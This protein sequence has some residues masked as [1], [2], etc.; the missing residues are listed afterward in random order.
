MSSEREPT[1]ILRVIARL[2]MGGPAL[3]VAYLTA[4]LRERGYDTT[5]VA[6]TLARG[7]DSMAF[8][9]EGLHVDVVSIPEL[10]REISPVRDLAATLRLAALIRRERPQILHTHTAKAGTVGRVA[11]L[12][13]GR[14][15]PPIVVHTFH[16][17]V[18]Y[19]YF[20][21]LRSRFFRWLERWLA[22]HTTVLVAVSP[23]VRDDLVALGVAPPEK[24]VVVR[25][26]IELGERVGAGTNGRA[27]TRRYL[28]I[29][30]DRFAVGWVGRMTAVK[31]TDDVLDGF[32]RL[33]ER[34]VGATLCLVGDGP[35]RPAL[36]R[37]AHE[38]GIMRQTLFLGYQED[39]GPLYAA[40]DALVLP[41]GNEGTPVSVIEA[42]AAGT[43]VVATRVGGVP[44]VVRDGEDG[45]LVEPGASDELAQRLAQ[46]AGDPDL[47]QRFGASGRA[48]VLPRY[49]VDR[50]VD[51]VD[52]L[53]RALLSE[54]A[55]EKR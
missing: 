54:A 44:D 46:L 32:K 28:G 49:A 5:L 29:P 40:F 43:P 12:L 24:F 6:G 20:G 14:A 17:H 41:S 37:R 9:A 45:F 15:R 34:G 16:G 50:L 1:K 31:R 33:L 48:R 26:G 51:D 23:Q 21:P 39:V 19:G 55:G 2:N 42:L 7:E 36:E 27:E 30:P 4:G 25:L 8:V 11:A 47:R 52:R 18:L 10:G 38:L 22:R 13:A 35:D 53:Y 3:H